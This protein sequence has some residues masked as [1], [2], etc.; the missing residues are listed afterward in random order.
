MFTKLL[1]GIEKKSF[2]IDFS[3]ENLQWMRT[4]TQLKFN[5]KYERK[6]IFIFY[7]SKKCPQK[8]LFVQTFGSDKNTLCERDIWYGTAVV[9]RS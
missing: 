3:S 2:N 1:Y 8:M 5:S 7:H 9:L 4:K 6:M